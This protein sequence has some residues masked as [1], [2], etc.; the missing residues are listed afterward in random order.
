MKNRMLWIFI[1]LWMRCNTVTVCPPPQPH[2]N[3]LPPYLYG[4]YC[5]RPSQLPQAVDG[6]LR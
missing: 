4:L 5:S 1:T 3:G 2:E 6:L